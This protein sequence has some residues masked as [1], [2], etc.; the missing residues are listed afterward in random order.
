MFKG[1]IFYV[2][3]QYRVSFKAVGSE[4]GANDIWSQQR[5]HICQ[6]KCLV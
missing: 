4:P 5:E 2:S 3:W 6:N 1:K